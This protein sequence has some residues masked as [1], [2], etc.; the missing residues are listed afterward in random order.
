MKHD[1]RTRSVSNQVVVGAFVVGMGLL[2]LLD[3]LDLLDLHHAISFWPM[4]FV[5][6][7]VLKLLDSRAPNGYLAG[8]VLIGVGVTLTLNRLGIWHVSWRTLWPVLLIGFGAAMLVKAL[9]ARGQPGGARADGA[10]GDSVLDITAILGGVERRLSSQAF[11]GGEV[12]AI[13]GGCELDLR[14]ASIEGEAIVHVFALFGGISIKCPTDWNV[15]LEGTPIM[16]GFEEKT[17]GAPTSG[18]RLVIRGYAIM[19]GVE[20]RN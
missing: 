17:V 11:R 15:V 18:K 10:D 1:A 12:T 2:F 5:L 8:L 16:G 7:G 20:V 9:G 19:G 6:V 4:A 3:N 13:M 14:A